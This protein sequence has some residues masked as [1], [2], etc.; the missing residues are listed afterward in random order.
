[1]RSKTILA[2]QQGTIR[3]RRDTLTNP[4]EEEFIRM[5]LA[6]WFADFEDKI[7]NFPDDYVVFD[8]ETTGTAFGSKAPVKGYHDLITQIGHCIVRNRKL[9]ANDGLIL[10]W[11]SPEYQA[12]HE[13]PDVMSERWLSDSLARLEQIFTDK[14]RVYQVPEARMR[15]DGADPKYVLEFYHDLFTRSRAKALFFVGHNACSFDSR[16]LRY[17]FQHY[18]GKDFKFGANELLDTG[19]IEKASQMTASNLPWP[20]DT[21]RDWCERI[22]AV[23]QRIKWNLDHHCANKYQLAERFDLSGEAHDAGFDCLLTHH[24]FETYRDIAAEESQGGT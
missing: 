10:N 22:Y 9:G 18:L 21:M 19:M 23:P 4:Q 6:T 14:G 12:L 13:Y 8:L 15:A 16:F 3:R 20:G 1:M 2:E 5:A 24:L 11:Y 7:G 17:H